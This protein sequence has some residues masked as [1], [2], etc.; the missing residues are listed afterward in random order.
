[1][2]ARKGSDSMNED[3]QREGEEFEYPPQAGTFTLPE[4]EEP[5]IPLDALIRYLRDESFTEPEPEA[6]ER[7]VAL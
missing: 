3:E 1:M 5:L 2:V 6:P 7:E 4:G